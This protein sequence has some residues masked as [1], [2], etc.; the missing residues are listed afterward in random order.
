MSPLIPTVT[1]LGELVRR[2]KICW[3]VWPEYAAAGQKSRQQVGFEL[4]LLGSDRSVCEFDPSCPKS[5]E[6]HAALDEIARWILEIDEQVSFQIN[7][8]RQSL[9]YARARGNRADVTL[10][11]QILSRK[12]FDNPVNESE[13]HCLE[14]AAA[15]LRGL[16]AYEHHW[17][18]P[19]ASNARVS[20]SA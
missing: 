20:A 16:G 3:E 14:R 1:V 6:I 18:L 19:P 11:I 4:E 15:R 10:S 9:C 7:D 5:D 17:H 13:R 2:Y 12:G 8:N